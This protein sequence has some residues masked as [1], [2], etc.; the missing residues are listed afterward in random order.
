MGGQQ[1]VLPAGNLYMG[2]CNRGVRHHPVR[3]N[4]QRQVLTFD[5][6]ADWPAVAFG[7]KT[8]VPAHRIHIEMRT[9]YTPDE[10][11]IENIL[12]LL[13]A[14]IQPHQRRQ[15]VQGT[16]APG[17]WQGSIGHAGIGV[18]PGGPARRIDTTKAHNNR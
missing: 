14:I 13:R 17:L 10:R 4:L 7:G 15:C 5:I 9:F 16:L 1:E 8:L 6:E 18:V 12:L 3:R 2:V 11:V